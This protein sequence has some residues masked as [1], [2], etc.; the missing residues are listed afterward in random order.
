M[1]ILIFYVPAD[2]AEKVKEALFNAGAGKFRNYDRC[3]WQTLGTGQFRALPGSTPFIG[4]R[5]KTEIVEEYRIEMVCEEK[6]IREALKALV[7]NHPYEEPA[8]HIIKNESDGFKT[9]Q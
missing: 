3:S 7:K 2:S 1:F 6:C 8:Y 5:M 4:T 9:F